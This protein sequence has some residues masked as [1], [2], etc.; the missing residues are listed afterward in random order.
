MA[1]KLDSWGNSS[2]SPVSSSLHSS[3]TSAEPPRSVEAFG[4]QSEEPLYPPFPSAI[5]SSR[6]ASSFDLLSRDIERVVSQKIISKQARIIELLKM[7]IQSSSVTRDVQKPE[8]SKHSWNEKDLEVFA[9]EK[10]DEKCRQCN[11][12][13][14]WYESDKEQFVLICKTNWRV[15]K[16]GVDDLT[17]SSDELSRKISNYKRSKEGRF[18]APEIKKQLSKQVLTMMV[19]EVLMQYLAKEKEKALSLKAGE[20]HP[21]ETADREDSDNN[22]ARVD[23]EIRG[24]AIGLPIASEATFELLYRRKRKVS[25]CLSPSDS[26]TSKR[27]K[28][29]EDLSSSLSSSE[30]SVV[31]AEPGDEEPFAVPHI[32][33]LFGA[34]YEGMN[35]LPDNFSRSSDEDFQVGTLPDY[36]DL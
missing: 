13:I 34:E 16:Q 1:I 7:L 30:S 36:F 23:S 27:P 10:F 21:C 25:P 22:P 28:Q 8:S 2:A 5:L 6:P 3:D 20:S 9:K 29:G 18:L 26:P 11:A 15:M 19:R 12:K 4:V 14:P 33:I 24:V 32:G 31:P 17:S 35:S